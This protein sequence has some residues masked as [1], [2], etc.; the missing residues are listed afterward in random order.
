MKRTFGNPVRAAMFTSSAILA[1]MIGTPA[2][3]QAQ[4]VAAP[5]PGAN[6]VDDANSE[7]I[8]VTAQRR[9]QTIKDI[10]QSVSVVGGEQL[11]RLQA[12]SFLDY[13]ALVPGLNVTQDFPGE[14][15]VILRGINTGSVGSTVAVYLDDIPFGQSG[16]LA[17][18][19]ILA[20]D[21]DTFDVERIEVLRGPQGTLYGS[22]S[23]G[24]VIKYITVAPALGKF[25]GKAQ[26]GVEFSK[27]GDVGYLSNAMINVPLGDKVAFRASGFYHKVPGHVD[28]VGRDEK[29]ADDSDSYGGRASLLFKPT[30]AL[31]VRLT[32]L[33]Q[34]IR[35]DSPSAFAAD[36]DTLKPVNPL[37]G[38][39]SG[40]HQQRFE[41]FKEFHNIDYRLFNGT[42]SYDFGFAEL[43]SVTSYGK[44][45]Q[46]QVTD[47]SFLP[48]QALINL[49]YAPTAPNT[50]GI[51]FPNNASSKKF[52][53]EVRLV[54][55]TSDK[56]EWLAGVYYTHEK[57]LLAQE[58]LPFDIATQQLLPT[59]GTFGPFVFD[60]FVFAVIDSKYKEIAGYASATA[61]FGPQFD[62]T[63][64]GRYSHNKQHSFQ[65]VVQL[66]LGDPELGGSSQGVFT[67]SI[68]PRYELND[69]AA[70]YARVAKGYRPGGPNF[71][72]PSPVAGF[73]S[74]FNADTLINYEVGLKAES[75]DRKF[76]ID[77][78]AFYIDWDNI[79]ILSTAD[80]AAGPVGVNANGQKARSYGAEATATFRPARGFNITLNGAYTKAY[81]RGDTVSA[82]T[83]GLNLAGGLDGDQL[84]FVPRFQGNLSANYDWFPTPAVHAYVGGNIHTQSDQKAG[85]DPTYR[86]IF[87]RQIELNGYTTVDLN[88]GADVGAFNVQL[89]ARNLF[90]SSGLVNAGDLYSI[91]PGLGGTGVN[92][93]NATSIRPRTIGVT[94][95]AR[96]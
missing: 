50:I 65:Q 88:A 2:F 79:L 24:G 62:L 34:N 14:S 29:N 60:R 33:F 11:E 77:A 26:A 47:I 46:D 80:S 55:P 66:G 3:A 21:F 5:A 4:P 7:S 68:A 38:L 51:A 39:R 6:N 8:I 93:I 37:T 23:L 78:A 57:V 71:I 85:F 76:S 13:A 35:T 25:E 32:G 42:L 82:T 15:R 17:N 56:F 75:A 58:F 70:V 30:D 22:N 91:A 20:G 36:P 9:E 90:N 28:V 92:L 48:T 19:A 64:G 95:G 94:V 59:A 83:G 69:H 27:G 89:Y 54:S 49:V 72:P 18:G 31:S 86:A 45:T 74:E 44:Q 1:L 10:P 63:V 61:H 52:T 12:K 84:P 53:Q 87:N 40:D 16:S 67:W 73:P 81:L 43:T 41:L 96:F